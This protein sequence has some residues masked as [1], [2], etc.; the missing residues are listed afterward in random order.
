M[1]RAVN[2]PGFRFMTLGCARG[3]FPLPEAKAGE[4]AFH[5]GSYIQVA[6]RDSSL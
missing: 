4:P 6:Y 2:A 1:L 3:L 5:C